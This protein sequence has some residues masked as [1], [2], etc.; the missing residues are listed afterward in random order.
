MENSHEMATIRPWPPVFPMENLK[1]LEGLNLSAAQQKAL[2][3][4][5]LSFMARLANLE[6]DFYDETIRVLESMESRD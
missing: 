1:I 3:L 2:A 4:L 6:K 5:K